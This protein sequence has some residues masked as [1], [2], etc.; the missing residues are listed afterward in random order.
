[1]TAVG[2]ANVAGQVV[3]VFPGQ[4]SQWLGM[5]VGLL[6]FAGVPGQLAACGEALA[7]YVDWSVIEVLWGGGWCAGVGAGRCRAAGV[8]CGDGVVG[9]VV[10]FVGV[11]PDAVV[12]HSQ[13]EIAAA[14]V[15]GGLSLGDAARVVA[16]RARVLMRLPG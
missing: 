2:R 9:G 5:A 15:A 16:L 7:E 1:M 13:G 14:Y 10:G 11:V 3:F 8:V 4:G 12:G 6:D